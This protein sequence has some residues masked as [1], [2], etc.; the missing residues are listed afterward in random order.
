MK[1][2]HGTHQ[3]TV[4]PSYLYF[5]KNIEEAKAF[6]LGLDDCGNYYDHSYIYTVEVDMNKVKIEEDFDIF[7]CLAYNET[8]EKP[9]YNPQTGWCI[10][11]N[12][13]L[14]LVES[15]KNEL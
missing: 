9:V 2:F 14:T 13:E 3:E 5:S 12:P 1:F 10:V 6:A 15:Y 7:D 4:N 8:L 11:P